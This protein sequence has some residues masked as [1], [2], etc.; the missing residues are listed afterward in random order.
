[1]INVLDP[2]FAEKIEILLKNCL[3]R[4]VHMEPYEKLRTPQ[5]QAI[6]WKQGRSKAEINKTITNLKTHNAEFLIDCIIS[7]SPNP[8]IKITNAL[9]GFS[10]HQWGEAIDC[11][12]LNDGKIN[13]DINTLDSEGIN[14][15]K[16]Y[17][18]E[19]RALKL[20]AGLYW[21]SFVDAPH[22]QLQSYASPLEIYNLYEINKIMEE[23]YKVS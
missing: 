10:W 16:I 1:M 4:G 20:D 22:V 8:G 15:Y 21:K 23:F 5:L 7:A 13:W 9:P 2:S 6:Y 19:A 17:A 18:E 3:Q 14:G 11:Y 12:W